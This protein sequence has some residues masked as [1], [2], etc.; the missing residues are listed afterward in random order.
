MFADWQLSIKPSKAFLFLRRVRFCGQI[1]ERGRRSA[2]PEKVA[3]VSG[4]DWRDIWTPTHLK[5]FLGLAQ[6]YAFHIDKFADHAAPL[7]DALRGL[8]LTK[9]GKFKSTHPPLSASRRK[10]VFQ[11][12]SSVAEAE[13]EICRLENR[14]HW[15]PEMI[16][17]FG[18]LKGKLLRNTFQIR[19]LC[20]RGCAGAALLQMS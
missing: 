10:A 13:K 20:G 1:L 18:Q 7:T 9:K 6:W 14:I 12:F 5:A 17:H 4:W 11:Q 8:D 3:A 19:R 15:T 2:D 16:W